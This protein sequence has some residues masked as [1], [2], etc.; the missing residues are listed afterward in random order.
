MKNLFAY[1]W[2]VL[3]LVIIPLYSYSSG[4]DTVKIDGGHF[5][6]PEETSETSPVPRPHKQ[7][8][9]GGKEILST[10]SSLLEPPSKIKD[11]CD[12][13]KS[14]VFCRPPKRFEFEPRVTMGVLRYSYEDGLTDRVK[15]MVF[16][17]GAG[18]LIRFPDENLIIDG[19]YQSSAVLRKS[20]SKNFSLI[21]SDDSVS[22]FFTSQDHR[23]ERE[24]YSV[25]VG[26][27][28]YGFIPSDYL[29]DYQPFFKNVWLFVGYKWNEATIQG[30][31]VTF[32]SDTLPT[33]PEFVKAIPS[34]SQSRLKTGG[35]FVGGKIQVPVYWGNT[36][37]GIIGLNAAVTHLSGDYIYSNSYITAEFKLS[38]VSTST[39]KYGQTYGID[40][41]WP[42]TT[43][44]NKAN[45]NMSVSL[46][47]YRYKMDTKKTFFPDGRSIFGFPIK[48][49]VYS[50]RVG[51][52]FQ[53]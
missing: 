50:L 38:E 45:L 37:L 7:P 12:V 32:F 22:S 41:E 49:S 46:N 14:Y 51:F 40:W 5:L 42:V 28:V 30:R 9:S 44:F 20:G 6:P 39:S 23:V 48:E 2:L 10:P 47:T 29:K 31:A 8:S 4:Q 43:V 52:I 1:S 36:S 3:S 35:P 25:N 16:M 34:E 21:G 53:F 15:G 13:W 17:W 24:D 11:D 27:R 18:L 33:N 26:Y 19:H